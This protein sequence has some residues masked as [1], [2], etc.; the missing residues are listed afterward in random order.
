MYAS[1]MPSGDFRFSIWI[2]DLVGVGTA[3][4]FMLRFYKR[5]GGRCRYRTRY[6]QRGIPKIRNKISVRYWDCFVSKPDASERKMT[7]ARR[8]LAPG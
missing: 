3:E 2:E 6:R 8:A 5:L 7:A 4:P 1:A